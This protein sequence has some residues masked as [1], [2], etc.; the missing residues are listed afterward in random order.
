MKLA[1]LCAAILVAIC[2][3]GCKG[4]SD[5]TTAANSKQAT[6]PAATA[7][8]PGAV[9]KG[10]MNGNDMVPGPGSTDFGSKSK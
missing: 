4:S 5:D 7:S 8:K 6:P 9:G 10:S 3:V 1:A 2:A